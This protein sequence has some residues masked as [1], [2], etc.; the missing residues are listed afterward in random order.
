MSDNRKWLIK[1]YAVNKK[2]SYEHQVTTY[3]TDYKIILS[4]TSKPHDTKHTSK[5]QNEMCTKDTTT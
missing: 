5:P 1:Y 2:Y 3:K 4:D